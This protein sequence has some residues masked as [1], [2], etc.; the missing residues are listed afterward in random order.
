MKRTI[1]YISGGRW[2]G[3]QGTDRLL[4]EAL[5]ST[6]DVLW[7]DQPVSIHRHADVRRDALRSLNGFPEAVSPSIS[8]LRLPALPGF[9]RP[10]VRRT[11]ESLARKAVASAAQKVRVAAVVNAS[12]VVPFPPSVRAP[13]LLHLT[14]DWLAASDLLGLSRR[15]VER[16][17][18]VN[19]ALADVITA[20][21]PGLAQKMTALAG[22]TVE[23]LPNGCRTP[24]PVHPALAVHHVA[25]LV[26][27]L[28]ERL[29]TDI[30]AGLGNSG[31]PL[32]VVGPRAERDPAMTRFLDGFLALPSVDWRGEVAPG[33]VARIL[34]TVAVG[35]TPYRVSEF[36]TS[37]FPLKTLEYLS[38]GLPVVATDLPATRWVGGPF[39]S[40]AGTPGEFVDLVR[41]MIA[42]PPGPGRRLAIQDSAFAHTWNVRAE[43]LLSLVGEQQT[44]EPGSTS[45]P[46]HV[47]SK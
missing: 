22:R 44:T 40:I 47:G 21:S 20:V 5:S 28:N 4:A 7:V 15:H 2:D 39:V 25:A 12:P 18:E 9:S 29:D 13:R 43:Q 1:M 23:V 36:N 8:R 35:L 30:L 32:V 27:Q 37:S 26:G 16:V 6:M 24:R 19:C 10:L 3:V 17:L 31:V 41:S 42:H 34:Q 46:R 45:G 11:T 14:D 33:E 38:S